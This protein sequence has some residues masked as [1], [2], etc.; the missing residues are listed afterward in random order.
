[1][2]LHRSILD[3]II[4]TSSFDT[5]SLRTLLDEVGLEVKSIEEKDNDVVFTIETLANRGDHL[6]AVGVA[7]EISAKLLTKPKS[8]S[9]AELEERKISI[10]VKNN[11]LDGCYKYALMEMHLTSSFKLPSYIQSVLQS[12][13]SK[14]PIVDILNYTALEI[15]QPM[16]AF[17]KDKVEGEVSIALTTAPEKIEA[18][19]GKTYEVPVDSVVIRDRKK[20]I[21]VAGVIGCANSMTTTETTKILVESATFD[22]VKVRKTARAMGISTDASHSFERGTDIENIIPALKRVAYLTQD[23][24]SNSSQIVGYTVASETKIPEQFVNKVTVRVSELKNQL[25]SPR[26]DLN[27]VFA[28]LKNLGYLIEYNTSDKISALKEFTV[29]VPSWR[30]WDVSDEQDIV[31]DFAKTTGLMSIKQVLPELDYI[32]PEENP[33]DILISKFEPVLIGN[34][35]LEVMTRSFYSTEDQNFIEKIDSTLSGK[36]VLLKNSIESS[37]AALKA[38]PIP[39]IANL[40]AQNLRRG[41]TSIKVFELGKVFT[42]ENLEAPIESENFTLA[43]SGR[44]NLGEWKKANDLNE[45][46]IKLKGVIINLLNTIRITPIF[47]ENKNPFLHPGISLGIY[48]GRNL[49]GH[50]GAIHPEVSDKYQ[51]KTPL[52]I[53]NLFVENLLK[54]KLKREF[55]EPNDLPQI[56]RDLTFAAHVNCYASSVVEEVNKIEISELIEVLIVDDFKKPN[57]DFRRITYRFCFQAKDRTLEHTFVD[58]KMS[59]IEQKIAEKLKIKVAD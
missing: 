2:K 11:T 33:L 16:H 4:D 40:I 22:P 19:D 25:Q 51:L 29:T 21:A 13:G 55:I 54:E 32:S 38:N 9:F 3:K 36:H 44:W 15:G 14:H 53:A 18:L 41:I 8:L 57:E 37:F 43:V 10:P 12:D 35:F 17:D 58:S 28:R 34:G 39:S 42:K 20:I 30:K 1:M 49:I 5:K 48:D 59:E 6:Y 50:I 23:G 26:L 47:K 24:S 52:V 56:R 46:V 45:L 27:E 31:E 7:R